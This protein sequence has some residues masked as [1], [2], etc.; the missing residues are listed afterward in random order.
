MKTALLTVLLASNFAFA[1]VPTS[2]K[3]WVFSYKIAKTNVFQ[4]KKSAGTYEEAFKSAAKEC[5]QQMTQGK[6]PGEEKGLAIIDIC[7]NPKS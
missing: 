7:A 5:Y 2:A 3:I 1:A 6:Y 4:I